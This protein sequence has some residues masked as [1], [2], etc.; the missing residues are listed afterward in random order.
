M[1]HRTLRDWLRRLL[2]PAGFKEVGAL[3]VRTFP[4]VS[5]VVGLQKSN[6][7]NQYYINLGIA[8]RALGIPEP[9]KEEVCHIRIR[10]EALL[11]PE[12]PVSQLLDLDQSLSPEAREQRL[13]ATVSPAVSKFLASS[14]DIDGLQTLKSSGLMSRAFVHRRAREILEPDRADHSGPDT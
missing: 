7:G 13:N 10:A 6:F 5:Q 1:T 2:N 14:R 3:W 9:M 4:E 11:D 8:I 12:S